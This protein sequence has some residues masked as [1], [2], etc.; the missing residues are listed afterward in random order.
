MVNLSIDAASQ[1]AILISN[2]TYHIDFQNILI[3]DASAG[4]P[5]IRLDNASNLSF[6]D[7]TVERGDMALQIQSAHNLS[8]QGSIFP[9]PVTIDDSVDLIFHDNGVTRPVRLGCEEEPGVP[10]GKSV[11]EVLGALDGA[12]RY[13]ETDADCADFGTERCVP[14]NLVFGYLAEDDM[15]ILPGLYYR[16]PGDAASCFE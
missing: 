8:I 14:A 1:S 16:C 15:C 9:A 7:L 3:H 6:R 5:A 2:T 10:P 4:I 12:S 11:L 13:C